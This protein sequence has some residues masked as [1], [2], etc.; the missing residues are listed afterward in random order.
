MKALLLSVFVVLLLVTLTTQKSLYGV[1]TQPMFH[2]WYL[3]W[4]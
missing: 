4:L 2:S 3:I 1:S